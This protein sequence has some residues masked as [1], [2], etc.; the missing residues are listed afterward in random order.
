VQLHTDILVVGAGVAGVAAAVTASRQGKK[1]LLIDSHSYPG[2]AATAAEVGTICGLYENGKDKQ[3]VFLVDGFAKEFALKTAACSITHAQVNQYGLHYLPYKVEAVKQLML[4]YLTEYKVDFLSETTVCE[5]HQEEKRLL[6]AVAMNKEQKT[7]V[8][9][10]DAVV[11]CSGKAIVAQLTNHQMIGSDYFQAASINFYVKDSLIDASEV[12]NFKLIRTL[13]T[14]ASTGKIEPELTQLYIIPGSYSE[15]LIGFK[16]TLPWEIQH[17]KSAIDELTI[18]AKIL[19]QEIFSILKRESELFT[20]ASIEHI[21]EDLGWRTGWRPL[22]KYI[23]T[24]SDVI[25]AKKWGNPAA[26][27]AW[28]IEEWLPDKMVDLA[29]VKEQDYYEI[30]EDCLMSPVFENLLFAGRIISATDR[31]IASTRVMGVCLQT[32]ETAGKLASKIGG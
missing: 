2:G 6:H 21:A 10:F 8:I 13:K 1:V 3:P 16:L 5:V 25:S 14:L 7:V 29:F 23:L 18:K 9:S 28:P 24:E 11:D 20:D 12:T 32:G 26:K 31:A 22:G 4:D 17:T 27:S 15:K 30:P 19:V